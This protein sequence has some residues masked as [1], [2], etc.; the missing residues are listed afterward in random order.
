MIEFQIFIL[1]R[2]FATGSAP[3]LLRAIHKIYVVL[4]SC[5]CMIFTH[6]FFFFFD[7][8]FDYI[9]MLPKGLSSAL[10]HL[11]NSNV[12]YINWMAVIH[13]SNYSKHVAIFLNCIAL[14]GS[15]RVGEYQW[16]S[17]FSRSSNMYGTFVKKL[18]CEYMWKN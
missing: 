7:F 17:I 12:R 9:Y 3:V 5:A 11:C 10:S 2:F 14:I 6:R 4:S 13:H 15:E 18:I 8:L 16:L 1:L